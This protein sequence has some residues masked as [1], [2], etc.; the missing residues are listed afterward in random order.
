M[1]SGTRKVRKTK[2][3]LQRVTQIET[4]LE[5][6]SKFRKGIAMFRRTI[7]TSRK[8]DVQFEDLQMNRILL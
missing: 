8:E 4:S 5:T 1:I 3:I 6:K 7:M 2:T